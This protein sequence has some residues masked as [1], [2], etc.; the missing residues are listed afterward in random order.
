MLSEINQTKNDMRSH[1]YVESKQQQ[2][3]QVY[4]YRE[5]IGD[6]QRQGVGVGKRSEGHQQVQTFISSYKVNNYGDKMYNMMTA[7][8]NTAYLK[9]AKIVKS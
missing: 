8:N 6:C 1:F 3:N 9:P 7:V 5:Q 4:R 2:Q